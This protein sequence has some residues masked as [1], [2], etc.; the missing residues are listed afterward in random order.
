MN[1]GRMKISFNSPVILGFSGICLV[2]LVLNFLTRGFANNLLF[3]VYR[4]SLLSPFTYFRLIGHIFGHAS[5]SHF[6]GNMTLILVLGPLLEEKYGS[7][8]TACVIFFTGL[9]TGFVHFMFFPHIQLLGASGVVFAFILLSSFTSMKEGE[10]PLTLI[11]VTLIYIGGEVYDGIFV[12]DNI[13]NLTHIL[14]GGVGAGF[15]YMMN[16]YQRKEI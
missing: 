13:S 10:I 9:I 11:L 12:R 8:N 7:A 16:V 6:I 5:W 2:A 4:S 14:G 1:K 3:S 15:G